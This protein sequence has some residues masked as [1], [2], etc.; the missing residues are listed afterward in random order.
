MGSFG[1]KMIKFIH[2]VVS[3]KGYSL[4]SRLV[5]SMLVWTPFPRGTCTPS[6]VTAA[7]G[8]GAV[9]PKPAGKKKFMN[10]SLKQNKVLHIIN[11]R[12]LSY[13]IFYHNAILSLEL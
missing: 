4:Y 11:T 2:L 13:Q 8:S 9:L 10:E 12:H 6:K 7:L 1:K 5:S 3:V